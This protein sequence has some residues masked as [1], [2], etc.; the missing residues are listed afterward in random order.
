M[1]PDNPALHACTVIGRVIKLRGVMAKVRIAQV[2]PCPTCTCARLRS[3]DQAGGRIILARNLVA[4]SPGQEVRLRFPRSFA[5]GSPSPAQLPATG[6]IIMLLGTCLLGLF[7]GAFILQWLAPFPLPDLNIS[8]GALV[9]LLFAMGIAKL[10]I[11]R[12]HWISGLDLPEI[13]AVNDP[14]NQPN[15]P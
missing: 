8:L 4:A 7:S 15:L 1:V 9:G 10:A 11:S 12:M 2:S 13:I 3:T 6:R 5:D 14:A